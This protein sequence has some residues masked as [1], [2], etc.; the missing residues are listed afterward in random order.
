MVTEGPQEIRIGLEGKKR[1]WSLRDEDED[2]CELT[3]CSK[4]SKGQQDV[5]TTNTS[6][7][8]VASLKWPQLDQ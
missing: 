2:I 7:V 1:P 8:E 4:R 6:K 3:E 5:L